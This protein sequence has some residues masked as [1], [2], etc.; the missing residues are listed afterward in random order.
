MVINGAMVEV[1][2]EV[3]AASVLEVVPETMVT[4]RT[5]VVIRTTTAEVVI[6][7]LVVDMTSVMS[8][9]TTTTMSVKE[10]VHLTVHHSKVLARN[11]DEVATI[12]V[13]NVGPSS[14][15]P[16]CPTISLIPILKYILIFK[17]YFFTIL[18]Y[19]T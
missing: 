7:I 10:S 19:C 9:V 11:V 12:E 15:I 5:T 13:I 8:L 2:V 4:L 6:V 3:A 14:I 1:A 17:L 16:T 18:Y